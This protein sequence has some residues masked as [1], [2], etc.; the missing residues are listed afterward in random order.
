MWFTSNPRPIVPIWFWESMNKIAIAL[1]L[2]C[3]AVTHVDPVA[4]EEKAKVQRGVIE[5]DDFT[6]TYIQNPTKNYEFYFAL[7][8]K[9]SRMGE[10]GLPYISAFVVDCKTLK[11][12]GVEFDKGLEMKDYQGDAINQTFCKRHKEMHRHS[13]W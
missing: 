1:F 2:L 3:S 11:V 9:T 12:K 13:I 4:A 10:N 7:V 6:A 5:N 8:G